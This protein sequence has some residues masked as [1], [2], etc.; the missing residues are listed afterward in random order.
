MKQI[1]ENTAQ[2]CIYYDVKGVPPP[3]LVASAGPEDHN[4]EFKLCMIPG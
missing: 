4:L 3:T 2:V 1:P